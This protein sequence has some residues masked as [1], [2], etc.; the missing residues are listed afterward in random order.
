MYHLASLETISLSS[1]LP[2]LFLDE[3][4]SFSIELS[5]KLL[6]DRWDCPNSSILG[7]LFARK[8]NLHHF[9]ST[10]LMVSPLKAVKKLAA[11]T[12]YIE[13]RVT[14]IKKCQGHEFEINKTP[15][16]GSKVDELIRDLSKNYCSNPDI[17]PEKTFGDKFEKG[18]KKYIGKFIVYHKDNAKSCS[19]K[20]MREQ[21]TTNIICV[22]ELLKAVDL[23]ILKYQLDAE[24]VY[25]SF[26]SLI[27]DSF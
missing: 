9:I 25:S 6:K 26:Y 22:A 17:L 18:N 7:K 11:S 15:L 24:K 12:F 4:L 8:Q 2:K 27:T 16:K 13:N 14:W 3:D 1:I 20:C 10:A 19:S 5:V 23:G 21:K